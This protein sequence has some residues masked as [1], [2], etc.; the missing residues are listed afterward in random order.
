MSYLEFFGLQK[1]PFRKDL[2]VRE[3][4][5]LPAMNAVRDRIRY[6]VETSGI[7]TLTGDIGLGKSTALRW[8]CAVR[9]VPLHLLGTRAGT[10]DP[11]QST[12]FKGHPRDTG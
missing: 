10:P 7:C 8:S 5:C 3:L 9:A 11:K 6:T 4:L 1:E 2:N 12:I